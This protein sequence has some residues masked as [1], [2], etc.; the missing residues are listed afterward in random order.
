M[1][2]PESKIT[3]NYDVFQTETASS[4]NKKIGLALSGGGFRA[5][6]F[7]IGVLS[8]LART[9]LL[10]QIDVIS[11]VSGGSIIGAY[12]YLSL[13][14]KKNEKQDNLNNDDYI[15][16]MDYIS[17]DFYD[18]VKK[19]I[20]NRFYSDYATSNVGFKKKQASHVFADLLDHY[21]FNKFA[22]NGEKKVTMK[23]FC[24][25]VGLP[26]LIL[27]ST[28]INLGC[29]CRFTTNLEDAKTNIYQIANEIT[30]HH[31]E[32]Y[33]FNYEEMSLGNAVGSSSCVPGLFPPFEI[34][35]DVSVLSLV[36]GGISDNSGVASLLEEKC[37]YIII[38]DASLHIDHV[39]QPSSSI[40]SMLFRTNDIFLEHQKK[41]IRKDVKQGIHA[42]IE[43][44]IREELKDTT[45]KFT[46]GKMPNT[47]YNINQ[48]TQHYISKIR[49]DLDVFTK[50]EAETLMLSG[51][52]IANLKLVNNEENLEWL[53]HK[54]N[55]LYRFENSSLKEAL[56]N[57]SEEYLK[58]LNAA[59]LRVHKRK[60]YRMNPYKLYE[61]KIRK[62]SF[63]G[64]RISSL[65][66]A[67]IATLFFYLTTFSGN[68]LHAP[69]VTIIVSLL[70]ILFLFLLMAQMYI[71]TFL[72]A[73]F[74]YLTIED[75]I[76][77]FKSNKYYEKMISNSLK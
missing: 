66:V 24:S 59:S 33:K 47:T 8:E 48:L 67:L 37:N 53:I 38:S 39:H 35:L 2:R 41:Q 19:G 16:I 32:G 60:K 18:S 36:D 50:L 65:V 42:V 10:S 75:K 29:P 44:N 26:K 17:S 74:L 68:E 76:Y 11:A 5:S 51:L 49:T 56:I 62:K 7:H 13:Q 63:L 77:Q 73:L 55:F 57:P 6:F 54:S 64:F 25:S 23:Q 43:I 4:S 22:T 70:F 31:P 27:N 69:V 40:T 14:K 1:T 28:N 9:G 3:L 52:S 21:F 15:E 71:P 34:D 46:N 20:R 45:P 58:L 61:K 72:L 12:Y 30:K